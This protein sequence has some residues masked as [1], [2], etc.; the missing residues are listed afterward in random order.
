MNNEQPLE[1]T[2]QEIF[3][4]GLAYFIDTKG[5]QY[6]CPREDANIRPLI[7]GRDNHPMMYQFS[8]PHPLAEPGKKFSSIPK[9]QQYVRAL[10]DFDRLIFLLFTQ[11]QS[12]A[13]PEKL[14][15]RI[16]KSVIDEQ[17]RIKKEYLPI[18]KTIPQFKFMQKY[19]DMTP[20]QITK[21]IQEQ[22]NFSMYHNHKF[23]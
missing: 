23:I 7:P 13:L 16:C 17:E 12:Q 18:L 3:T 14:L 8:Q 5:N 4:D 1:L 2:L 10:T 19:L 22:T 6:F 20:E 9:A 21:E 11:A 15:N